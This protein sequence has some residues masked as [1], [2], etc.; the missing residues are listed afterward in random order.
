VAPGIGEDHDV[1]AILIDN[2]INVPTRGYH[3]SASTHRAG[4]SLKIIRGNEE[5]KKKKMFKKKKERKI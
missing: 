3:P 4:S 2:D 1:I 5:E